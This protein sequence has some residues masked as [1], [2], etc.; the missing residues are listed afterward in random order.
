MPQASLRRSHAV[1]CGLLAIVLVL[2][3]RT[4]ADDIPADVPQG[5]LTLLSGDAVSGTF[6]PSPNPDVVRWQGADFVRPFE[7]PAG[8][9]TSVRFPPIQPAAKARGEFLIELAPD[10]VLTG[11]LVRWTDE[12]VEIDTERFGTL[13]VR[14]SAVRRLVRTD[15]NPSLVFAGLTGIGGWN[16]PGTAW[17]EDGTQIFTSQDMAMASADVGIPEKA[18]IEFELAWKKSASFVLALGVN[19]DEKVD[20]R[21]EG[22]RFETWDGTLAIVRE[23]PLAADVDKVMSISGDTG[24]MQL[25]AYLDQAAGTMQVFL[26]D[27]TPAGKVTVVSEAAAAGVKA[28][29]VAR[30]IRLVNRRGELRLEKLRVSRWNGLLPTLK[31]PGQSH[32]D[33]AD[34]KT[35]SGTITG[36]DEAK[37]EF[38]VR[39]DGQETRV[40]LDKVVSADVSSGSAPSPRF[41]S[42]ALQDGSRL[43]GNIEKLGA[44]DLI[45]SNPEIT[46]P[47]RMRYSQLHGLNRLQPKPLDETE[48]PEGRRGR[49]EIGGLKLHGRLAPFVETADASSIA[50]HPEG[51][52]TSSPLLPDAAGK[53]VYRD[54]PPPKPKTRVRPQVIQQQP[55][56]KAVFLG[57]V[58]KKPVQKDVAASHTLH[59][60][61]GD[62]IPCTIVSI[63][64]AGVTVSTRADQSRVVPHARI[65]AIEMR[66]GTPHPN[67]R[68]AKKQRLLTLP[69]LQKASP[70]TQL[71]CS[72]TGD[73]L[74]CRLL[75]MDA[76]KL[77]LEMQLT[78][79]ELPRDR[80]AHIIWFHPDEITTAED[81]KKDDDQKATA[82]AAAK[83]ANVEFVAGG[84]R[85]IVLN[86]GQVVQVDDQGG[87]VRNEAAF[88]GDS[89]APAI[90]EIPRA[91]GEGH[92]VQ[93]LW[94]D[95]RRVTFDPIE[96]D[97][98]DISGVSEILGPCR[99]R[100]DEFDQILFGDQIEV[101][102][103]QLA[104]H[105]WRLRHAVEPLVAQDLGNDPGVA[106][107]E[108]PLV[109]K[110]APEI[111]LALLDGEPF[112]L[113]ACK[114][115]IVV[116]DF[117]ASWCGPCMR[118]M[119]LVEEAIAGYDP[120]RVR[121]VSINLEESAAQVQ[122]ALERQKLHVAVALDVDGVAAR[123]YEANAIPQ[124][125]VV[126]AEGK[127]ARLY[128]GGGP[129][130]VE[131]MKESLDQL[132]K[133]GESN[134]GA[135]GEKPAEGG[136]GND[137]AKPETP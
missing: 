39:A 58:A 42:V 122:A 37:R 22:W 66:P 117:W 108:S 136:K 43:S 4:R 123:R 49:L 129:Q 36:F 99:Y 76:E 95:G 97:P 80:I 34:G 62:N 28:K 133:G 50:W 29:P 87:V 84:G 12:T 101:A 10:D 135:Q 132:L 65:K 51:S 53:I 115:Q 61:S 14:R 111:D 106:G 11:R 44:A 31:K 57:P 19:P 81:A 60:R 125:V 64:E 120:K 73:F 79:I 82:K 15:G 105:Q 90:A 55:R 41:V 88:G 119:P 96:V 134:Q 1:T 112:K 45:L 137:A 85:L 67:L 2:A 86:N 8:I 94:Q 47:L 27:G 18:L 26:P 126:D 77:R 124:L 127:V 48:K 83:G 78:E 3:V 92:L 69:R 118:T 93:L 7:F 131:R 100:I 121:L 54:P 110:P 23:Q 21:Q 72:T 52:L 102:A 75:S 128:V 33:L 70:P 9:V 35:V 116:L 5:T 68:D 113:S 59:L 24:R 40:P 91:P 104:W 71:L 25:T 103:G 32:L 107:P 13:H 56:P 98:V 17:R 30:G 63:D 38:T 114:G 130:V 89:S 46:E 109:G 6:R 20:K 16:Q 74:R